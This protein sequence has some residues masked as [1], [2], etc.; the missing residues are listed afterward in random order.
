MLGYIDGFDFKEMEPQRYWAPPQSWPDEK[1]KTTTKMRVFSGEFWGAEKK[2]GYFMKFV[3]DDEGNMILL[4][5]SRNVKGEFPNKIEWVPHL[6][7]FFN[8]IPNGTCFLCEIYLP[9]KPGSSN[10]TTLLGCLKDKAIQRQQSTNNFL[11]LYI[12]DVLAYRGESWMVRCAKDRFDSLQ[13][14]GRLYE[15]KFCYFAV[16]YNG[17]EL[18]NK[19]QSY[20]AAGLEGV[21]ITRDG[22]LYQPGKRPSKDCQKVKK[23]VRQT[24]DLVVLGAN[25]PT[26]IYTGKSMETWPYWQNTKTGELL[27]VASHWREWYDGVPIE[28]ITK[29]YY[30]RWA[31]SLVLGAKRNGKMVPV[32]NLS[33]LTEEVLENWRDYVGKVVE[34]GAMEVLKD[35]DGDFSGLRHPKFICWREDKNEETATTWEELSGNV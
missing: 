18:W 31:G 8:K 13:F 25:S 26:K 6:Q 21:V 30:N 3:K 9:G 1:K 14:L 24:I 12:F 10:I 7:P 32:G 5:R 16:Y 11:H 29:P 22:A 15:D 17:A 4:S 33:G 2:D 34:V 35:E 23:E 20:L 27:P 28:P 19:I